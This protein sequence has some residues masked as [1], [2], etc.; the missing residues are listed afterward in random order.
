VLPAFELNWHNAAAVAHICQRLDGIPLAIELAAARMRLL[1]VAEI[2]AR[3]DDAFGLLAGG[4]QLAPA[5]H[6]TLRATMDWSY[7][8]LSEYEQVLFRRMAVFSGG[9]SLEAVEQVCTDADLVATSVL[10]VLSQL[11]DKSLVMADVQVGGRFDEVKARYRLLATIRDY[12]QER[13]LDSG[14]SERLHES[15]FRYFLEFAEAIEPTLR[16]PQQVAQLNR[17]EM[18]HD[19]LRAALTHA[20]NKKEEA[21]MGLRLAIALSPFWQLRDHLTEGRKWIARALVRGSALCRTPLRARALKALMHFAKFQGDYR[22]AQFLADEALALFREF[23]DKHGI[24]DTLLGLGNIAWH[25]S[26]Y[27]TAQSLLQQSLALFRE[28]GD[29]VGV[30]DAL[31]YLGHTALDQGRHEQANTLFRD[32]LALFREI[33]HAEMIETLVGDVGLV[34]YLREDY[35]TA[36]SSFEECLALSREIAS[37][38][39]VAR[40]LDR[41]GDLARCASDDARAE[42]LY[43]ASLALYRQIG[44]KAFIASTLHNLGYVAQHRGDHPQATARFQESLNLFRDLGDKKGIAECLMGLAGVICAQGQLQR[45]ARL[46]G[47]AEALREAVGAVLWPANRIEYDR[48]VAALSA[49]ISEDALAAAWAEGRALSLEQ[50]VALAL[51][52]SD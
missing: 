50:A 49:Q 32:S 22:E 48:N 16:G 7:R 2:A 8:L 47:A 35:A 40:A 17:L 27:T 39:G 3:L 18:E 31:H 45:A 12:A 30:A 43:T 24:A 29:K 42:S 51:S 44:H 11:I 34:A 9:C 36:R 19:N 6:Q 4:S 20:L 5:R 14:E 13:L 28:A 23:G 33:G 38:D 41:L 52:V 26:D 1:T 25:Q 37:K 46:F 15:H 10:E 21:E